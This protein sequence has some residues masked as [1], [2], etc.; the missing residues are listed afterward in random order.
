MSE[1]SNTR[2][3]YSISQINGYVKRQLAA[4]PLLGAVWLK[5]EIS[6]LKQYSSGHIYFTLKDPGAAVNAVMFSFDADRLSFLPGNGMSVVVCGAVTL[7]E[8]TGSYQI[9]VKY[10]EPDGL[11]AYYLAFEELK[12]RL[13]AEGLFNEEHK[14][15]IPDFPRVIGVATSPTGAVIHDIIRT[16]TNKNPGVRILLA[17]AKVQGDDAPETIISAIKALEAREDVDVIIVGRGGGSIEDLWA[18]NNEALARAIFACAKPV[19]SAVGH[20][21]DWS[22]CDYVADARAATPTAAAELATPDMYAVLQG[23]TDAK[24]SMTSAVTKLL[25]ANERRLSEL[26][27]RLK[28]LSPGAKIMLGAG[29][30]DALK[31]QLRMQIAQAINAKEYRVNQAKTVLLGLNPEKISEKGLNLGFAKIL[32]SEGKMLGAEQIKAGDNVRIELK[33]AV[34]DATIDGIKLK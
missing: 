2:N 16:A 19:I 18:F 14:K 24:T 32:D 17:P 1:S 15:A 21:T 5:G 33:N 6:N 8:K 13:S 25:D 11:G 28:L 26:S 10:M 7:Y 27:G 34:A 9:N 3:I 23:I 20:E 30:L 4:N 12:N 22:I 29:R 31:Q